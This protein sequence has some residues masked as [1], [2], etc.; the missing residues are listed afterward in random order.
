VFLLVVCVGLLLRIAWRSERRAA[1]VESLLDHLTE[2]LLYATGTAG[3]LSKTHKRHRAAVGG[4]LVGELRRLGEEVKRRM[5]ATARERRELF[6]RALGGATPPTEPPS[7]GERA[8][9][10]SHELVP[11]VG[12]Q[13]VAGASTLPPDAPTPPSGFPIAYLWQNGEAKPSDGEP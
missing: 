9:P 13:A 11:L 10:S 6:A 3:R 12:L 2:S 7:S 5:E 4:K 8:S 1:R